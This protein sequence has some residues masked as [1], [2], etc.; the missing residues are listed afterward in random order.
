MI[1]FCVFLGDVVGEF[2]ILLRLKGEARRVGDGRRLKGDGFFSGEGLNPRKGLGLFRGGI[3]ELA[4]AASITEDAQGSQ[5]SS[6]H[7]RGL[8]Y[9]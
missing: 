7:G 1:G 2:V 5:F 8:S 6:C 9:P 4:S 3:N